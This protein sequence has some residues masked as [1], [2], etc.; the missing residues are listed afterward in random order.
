MKDENVRNFLQWALP[1]LGMRWEGF[2]K[3]YGQLEDRL[4]DRLVELELGSLEGYREYLERHDEEWEQLDAL[5]YVTISRFYRAPEV[6]DFLRSDVLPERAREAREAGRESVD[7]WCA[8]AASGEEPYSIRLCWDLDVAERFSELDCR[9]TATEAVPH[10]LERA[11]RACYPES[12]LRELPDGW[13]KRAFER[14]DDEFCLRDAL[15][16]DHVFLQQDVRRQQPVGPFDIVACRNL[17]FTY[18]DA[19]VQVEVLESLR[20]RLRPGGA[21]V[22]GD[23]EE[24]PEEAEGFERRGATECVYR[25]VSLE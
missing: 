7:V 5:C 18:F 11:L 8:G 4:R 9:I 12:S 2:Q 22:I 17:V 15:R 13:R 24:L 3:V 19:S 1:R 16:H 10:M 14:R 20:D 6:F 21:L 23:K 25:T